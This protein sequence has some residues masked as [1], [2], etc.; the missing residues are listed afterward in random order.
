MFGPGRNPGSA[1]SVLDLM[2]SPARSLIFAMFVWPAILVSPARAQTDVDREAINIALDALAAIES[3]WNLAAYDEADRVRVEADVHGSVSPP[4]AISGKLTL[5]KPNRRWRLDT[6]GDLGP[7]S[8]FVETAGMTL[9]VPGLRQFAR[10]SGGALTPDGTT[11]AVRQVRVVRARLGDEYTQLRYLGRETV[12]GALSERIEDTPAPETSV[13]YWIDVETHL[14]RRIVVSR[15]GRRD[16]SVDFRYAS[17]TRPSAV[18]VY[19]QGERDVQSSSTLA[20][21]DRGRVVRAVSTTRVAGGGTFNSEVTFD[22]TPTVGQG[23]FSFTPPDGTQEVPFPQLVTGVLFA[24]A[25]KLSALLP[26]FQGS[27]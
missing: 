15:P 20:Y 7:L 26:L 4:L 10:Q 25:G 9:Y 16:A 27:L 11:S 19:L 13:T 1:S 8:L 6:S 3:K 14:P 18:E 12:D 22:W 21:D 17:G 23:F 2:Q 5:D 24:A